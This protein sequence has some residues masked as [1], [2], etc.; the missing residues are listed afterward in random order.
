MQHRPNS[1]RVL[2]CACA[3]SP[4][5]VCARVRVSV[6]EYPCVSVCVRARDV[7]RR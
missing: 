2:A 6:C 7:D 1:C 4:V 3:T 5:C